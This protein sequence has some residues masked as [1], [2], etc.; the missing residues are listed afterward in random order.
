MS[1]DRWDRVQDL[2]GRAADLRPEEREGFLRAQ[3]AGDDSLYAEVMSLIEADRQQHSFLDKRAMDLFDVKPVSYQEGQRIG[4]YQLIRQIAVG[5]MGL[6]FLA[7]RADGQYTQQVALKLIKRGM[8]SDEILRRF[9]S[10]RQILANLNHPNIAR[11]IDGG[12]TEHGVPWFSMEYVDGEPID[13]Y[14]DHQRMT[15]RERLELFLRVCRTVQYAQQNLVVHRDLKPSNI[16]VTTDAAVKLLDFGIAKMLSAEAEGG[17]EVDLTRTGLRVM[18]PGY[19]SPEQ[20]RGEGVTTSTDVYS[21]GVVLYRLLTGSA[22]YR[23]TGDTPNEL[24]RVICQTDPKRPSAAV[25]D[26]EPV[27]PSSSEQPAAESIYETRRT[28]PGRL[29]RELAGDLDNICLM[30]LRKEP[31]RRYQTAGQLADDIER[32][33]NRRPI[34]A[35]SDSFGYRAGKFIRRNRA[36][37]IASTAVILLVASLVVVYTVKLQ[38]ERDRAQQEARKAEEVSEFLTG[39]FEVSD[40]SESVGKTITAREL[41][42]RGAE[43]I[44]TELPDQPETQAAMMTVVGNVYHQLGLSRRADTL[45]SQ[46]MAIWEESTGLNHPDAA[47]TVHS[48]AV[49]AY[50]LAEYDRADLLYRQSLQVNRDLY[51]EEHTT[52]AETINNLGAVYKRQGDLQAARDMFEKALALRLRL[53]GEMDLGVAHSMNHLGG[54]LREL[55]EYDRAEQLLRRGLEIRRELV[56]PYH[57]ETVASMGNMARFHRQFEEYDKAESLYREALDILHTMVGSEHRYVAGITGSLAHVLLA[58]GD[59]VGA[60]QYYRNSLQILNSVLPPGNLHSSGAMIGLANALRLQ[61]RAEEAEAMVREALEIRVSELPTKHWQVAQARAI[62]GLCLADMSQDTDAASLLE[63][64]LGPLRERLGP[65]HWLP[66]EADDRLEEIL[67]GN[68]QSARAD[69]L[70][71]TMTVRTSRIGDY[72][73]GD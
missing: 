64:S 1:S 3:C 16:M 48:L 61:G 51:G 58:K 66:V 23:L 73:E 37:A 9:S 55:G 53:T 42:D 52:V 20:V 70:Q 31:D 25:T 38:Q 59:Y 68:G 72:T 29:Q 7:E 34:L 4:P 26:S 43:R 10:E 46:A 27:T 65:D 8:D 62:L 11:L 69:S 47:S 39:L 21:L 22:P 24:E 54:I 63:S 19:A 5:G 35:R 32:H 56:G 50:D 14:C 15:V 45:L 40:P 33:L 49:V 12:L 44:R 6:V 30:A 13:V 18:T 17:I 57:F 28:S 41:L 67:N 2:F 60:E 71:R 36:A